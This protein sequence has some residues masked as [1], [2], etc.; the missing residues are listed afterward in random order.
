MWS[1]SGKI[2]EVLYSRG[3]KDH[4][5]QFDYDLTMAIFSEFQIPQYQAFQQSQLPS[6]GR[7]HTFESCIV[8]F[9]D[10]LA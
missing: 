6:H 8:H 7:G 1:Q 10:V 5:L 3:L 2:A 4:E 9:L